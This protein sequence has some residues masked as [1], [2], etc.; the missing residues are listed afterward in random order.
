[1]ESLISRISS[2]GL[3]KMIEMSRQELISKDE[4]FQQLEHEMSE[5]EFM[6]SNLD[7][8]GEQGEIIKCYVEILNRV[9]GAYG[10]ISYAAGIKDAVQ[11]LNSLGLL[12]T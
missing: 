10:D 12:K 4:Q 2:L 6:Y 3:G 11:L 7:L 9:R 8:E 5:S 1:M